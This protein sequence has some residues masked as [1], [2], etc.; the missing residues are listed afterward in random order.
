MHISR[1]KLLLK[2]LGLFWGDGGCCRGSPD[3][4]QQVDTLKHQRAQLLEENERM[5]E[6]IE[7][8][9][10]QSNQTSREHQQQIAELGEEME[11]LRHKLNCE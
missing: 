7:A 1:G 2:V 8:Q 5:S 10:R 11:T 6:T 9:R 3:V 4:Y